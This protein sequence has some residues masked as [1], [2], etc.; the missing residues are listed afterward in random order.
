MTCASENDLEVQLYNLYCDKRSII[1]YGKE[2]VSGH[3]NFI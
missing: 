3:D 2:N 1:A